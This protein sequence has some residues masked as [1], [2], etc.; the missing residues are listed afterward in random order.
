MLSG[1]KEKKRYSL[2]R[3][4]KRIHYQQIC[5]ERTAKGNSSERNNMTPE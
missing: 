5:S 3:K 4:T 2:V 1:M